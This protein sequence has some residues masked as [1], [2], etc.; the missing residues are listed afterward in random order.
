MVSKGIALR[1]GIYF[2]VAIFCLV[3]GYGL[4]TTVAEKT[5]PPP[6]LGMVTFPETTEP[7]M[8]TLSFREYDIKYQFSKTRALE[9]GPNIRE[10]LEEELRG[11]YLPP[12]EMIEKIRKKGY[13]ISEVW[14]VYR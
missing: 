14:I 9:L 3:A 1:G 13:H 6:A 2:L 10:R 5:S 4:S 8:G 11:E 7:L 12:K